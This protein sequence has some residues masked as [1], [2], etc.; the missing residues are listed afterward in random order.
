VPQSLEAQTE[1]KHISAAKHLLIGPQSSKPNMAIVQDSLLGVYKMTKGTVLIPKH[2]FYDITMKLDI[3]VDVIEKLKHIRRV[4]KMKGKKIQAFTG[5][6]LIS[7]FL[8]QDLHYENKNNADPLEPV[9]KI[10]RGVLYEGAFN[11][12]IVGSAHNSLIQIINKE[13]GPDEASAFIDHVQF[14]TNAWLVTSTFTVGLNDC[15]ITSAESQ[16]EIKAVV[17]R[18]YIEAEGVK[19]TTKHAGIRE[20]RVNGALSKARDAGMRLAKNALNPDNAFISTV[21]SGSKGDYF[22]IAQIT[23]LLG[24]QS[25]QGQR[26][27]KQLNHGQRTLYHYPFGEL[28][29]EREYESRGFVTS[30]FIKGLN[31]REYFMHAISGREG[32]SNTSLSTSIS[33]YLQR[34]VVKLSEDMV[35][36]QDG[37]VRDTAGKI[38]QLSYGEDGI[39]PKQLVRV[40]GKP[41]I[42]DVGRIVDRLNDNVKK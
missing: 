35:T 14:V 10:Y 3:R 19:E 16:Q 38:Y 27:P 1:L 41:E 15:M 37:S 11:K 42:C 40:N 12:A 33:G 18:Y 30:S 25:I 13:Y 23:G 21:T 34:S 20:M 28:S 22:N 2:I 5:K 8:P 29:V 36:Q 39:E 7:F 17:D 32:V 4:L 9:V 26:I 31:P 6:G 24:Q